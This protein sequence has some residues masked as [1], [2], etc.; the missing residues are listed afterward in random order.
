MIPFHSLTGSDTT[1]FING[2]SKKT[3]FKVFESN[4]QLLRGIGKGQ[5]TDSKIRKVEKFMCLIYKSSED[6]VDSAQSKMF[7]SATK[8]EN[9]PPTSDALKFHIQRAHYQAS[10]W[11]QAFAG[12]MHLTDP[13]LFGWNLVDGKYKPILGSITAVPQKCVELLSCKYKMG[14]QTL[15]CKCRKNKLNCTQLCKCINNCVNIV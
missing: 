15:L 4:Y 11:C 14:C 10:I 2:H 9:L 6:S 3:A 12:E 7:T 5:L 8:P 1:S 13:T